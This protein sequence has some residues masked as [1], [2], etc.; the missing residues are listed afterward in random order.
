M[1]ALMNRQSQD[2]HSVLIML[3]FQALR[4]FWCFA[5]FLRAYSGGKIPNISSSDLNWNTDADIWSS[6]YLEILTVA[7]HYT[8]TTSGSYS[9]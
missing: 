5:V 4:F 8:P 3:A 7:L 2:S 9:W 1:M 6:E